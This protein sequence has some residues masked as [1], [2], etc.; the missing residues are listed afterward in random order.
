MPGKNQEAN[1]WTTIQLCRNYH[2]SNPLEQS[3]DQAKHRHSGFTEKL[4]THQK[5]LN[6]RQCTSSRPWPLPGA[7]TWQLHAPWCKPLGRPT[8]IY[9][10][11]F[12]F[13][14]RLMYW[15][16]RGSLQ[17]RKYRELVKVANKIIPLGILDPKISA[18]SIGLIIAK[19]SASFDTDQQHYK[20]SVMLAK[21]SCENRDGLEAKSQKYTKIIY[22]EFHVRRFETPKDPKPILLSFW[23]LWASLNL[24]VL[25][26]HKDNHQWWGTPTSKHWKHPDDLRNTKEFTTIHC[27]QDFLPWQMMKFSGLLFFIF[28]ACNMEILQ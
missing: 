12:G 20:L 16:Q 27:F 24:M 7:Y 9:L 3:Q 2:A 22:D 28:N 18:S 11:P 23:V 19:P 21:Q 15:I 8:F 1:I 17:N 5:G 25:A 10:L 26:C 14:L 6:R 13:H 4:Q